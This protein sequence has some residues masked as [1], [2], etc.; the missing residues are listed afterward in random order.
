MLADGTRLADR[1]HGGAGVLA[2]DAHLGDRGIGD[3]QLQV[4]AADGSGLLV[5]PD[6][7]VAW[8]EGDGDLDEALRR[9][10]GP[11]SVAA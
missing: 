5:R 4:V 3:D 10:F 9:W 2:G 1:L 8:V 6:G 11:I 7:I